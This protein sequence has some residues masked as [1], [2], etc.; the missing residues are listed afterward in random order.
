MP[1]I[2]GRGWND[3][4]ENI[5]DSYVIRIVGSTA[6]AITV[7][8][9]RTDPAVIYGLS[10]TISEAGTTGRVDINDSSA[11]GDADPNIWSVAIPSGTVNFQPYVMAFPRGMACTAGIVVT[12]LT[13]TGN[14]CVLYKTRYS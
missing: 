5:C 9:T 2:G 7:T 11:T 14:I 1:T 4:L 3:K 6:T 13:V 10:V 8:G 12:A